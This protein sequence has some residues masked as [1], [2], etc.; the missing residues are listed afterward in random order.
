MNVVIEIEKTIE[1]AVYE[2]SCECGQI[3]KFKASADSDSDILVEVE[4]H[5]C[6]QED[7]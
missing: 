1:V 4:E 5:I 6:I 3:L 2:V 7:K